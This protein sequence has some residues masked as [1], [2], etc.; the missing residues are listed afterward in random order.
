MLSTVGTLHKSQSSQAENAQTTPYTLAHCWG[1]SNNADV[2]TSLPVSPLALRDAPGRCNE[3]LRAKL[4][5]TRGL[6]NQ[7][8]CP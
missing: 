5:R 6:L 1:F 4:A 3:S 2:R 7:K 8:A